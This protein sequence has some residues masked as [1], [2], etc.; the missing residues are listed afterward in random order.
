MQLPA[1]IL[2]ALLLCQHT[3]TKDKRYPHL[4]GLHWNPEA[5]SLCSTN[6]K[7]MFHVTT[8]HHTDAPL[9]KC[10]ITF[11][12]PV[13]AKATQCFI[14]FTHSVMQCYA[15]NG[16][17]MTELRF[18]VDT[19]PSPIELDKVVPHPAQYEAT[20]GIKLDPKH[21]ALAGKIFALHDSLIMHTVGVTKPLV[22]EPS[23]A[24]HDHSPKLIIMPKV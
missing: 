17:L 6:A 10:A 1:Y 20:T 23:R 9:Y 11:S 15:A 18:T 16:N 21:L 12:K 19:S 4:K 3:D 8:P 24:L 22:I 2:R 7:V 13:P 5:S 14:N